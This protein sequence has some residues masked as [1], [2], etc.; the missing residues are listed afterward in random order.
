[1]KRKT[2]F[3]TLVVL[4]TGLLATPSPPAVAQ[5]RPAQ[6]TAV[7]SSVIV[8]YAPRVIFHPDEKLWPTAASKFISQS[9]LRWSHAG[10]PDHE[11]KSL[12][13]IDQSKLGRRSTAP[14]MHPRQR[15]AG[16]CI[17]SNKNYKTGAYTRPYD[18]AGRSMPL[19]T[20]GKEGFFLDHDNQ[21]NRYA[22]GMADTTTNRKYDGGAPLYYEQGR[23]DDGNKWF[24]TYWFFHAK[25]EK[26]P[27]NHEGD[28]ERVAVLLSNTF[29]AEKIVYYRHGESCTKEYDFTDP[30]VRKVTGTSHPLVYSALGSHGSYT[31]SGEQ[32]LLCEHVPFVK[33]YTGSGEIWDTWGS[34]RYH[35]PAQTYYAFGGA[36]GEIGATT[37]TS[38]PLGPGYKKASPWS[39]APPRTLEDLDD[40]GTDPPLGS[41]NDVS[42]ALNACVYHVRRLTESGSV[43]APGGISRWDLITQNFSTADYQFVWRGDG[44]FEIT[45]PRAAAITSFVYRAYDAQGQPFRDATVTIDHRHLGDCPGTT[46]A[47][48]TFKAGVTHVRSLNGSQFQLV[49]APS[50]IGSWNLELIS[51]SAADYGFTWRGDG[52][53]EI[54]PKASHAN[55]SVYFDFSITNSRGVKSNVSR[56]NINFVP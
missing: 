25:N 20:L 49:S 2:G 47:S 16:I 30:A 44:A 31:S 41:V 37:H 27:V 50:G 14:Y 7:P 52:S 5:V 55:R 51:F 15:M 13:T 3:L 45:P 35:L 11:S 32:S 17:D 34:S 6:V 23:T 46:G 38:G 56:V 40:D 4:A 10:C 39:P 12:G 33:D 48:M 18:G 22:A 43:D 54:K 53:F 29:V 1:M 24:V 21:N 28:W 9:S 8:K 36:W 42:Y 26:S 19:R